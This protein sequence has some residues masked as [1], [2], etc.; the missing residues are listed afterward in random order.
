MVLSER[1]MHG[2]VKSTVGNQ[3]AANPLGELCRCGF[4]YLGGVLPVV[5]DPVPLP[6]RLP[7]QSD[8]V[9]RPTPFLQADADIGL[10][11]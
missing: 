1:I 7:D 9:R 6:R 2:F 10:A 11:S 5:P 3:P 8:T 4:G